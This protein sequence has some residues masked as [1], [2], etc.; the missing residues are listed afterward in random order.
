MKVRI[1]RQQRRGIRVWVVDWMD[2]DGKR[3]QPQFATK[4]EAEA[5]DERIRGTLR[6][7]PSGSTPELPADVTWT[8]LFERVMASRA[9]LK[10]RTL[11][12]YR[13]LHAT[14]IAPRFGV[15]AVRNLTRAGLKTFLREKRAGGLSASTVRLIYAT[16]HVVL[17]EAAEDGVL[18]G[19]P[20]AGLAKKLKLTTKAK[21]RQAAVK[22]K[23][24]TRAQRDAFLTTAET[25]APWWAPLWTVQ[26]LTGLRPG[27]M[28]ALEEGDL[29]L[30]H[31]TLT[32]ARTLSDDGERVDTPKSGLTRTVDLTNE[33]GRVLRAQA[34]RRREEK[35]R[36]GWK[37]LPRPLF[38]SMA[39]TY[40]DPADVRRAFRTVCEKA[41]LT[42]DDGGGA[43]FSPHSLRHTT[44]ALLLQSGTADVYYVQRMLGHADIALT[45]GTYG[46]WHRPDR[47]PNLDALDRTTAAPEDQEA[48]A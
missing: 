4:E 22:K 3:H 12:S 7:Q 28:Y 39:G 13:Y 38:P 25:V 48:Q 15:T 32:V 42:D 23:A 21:A 41:G 18:P 40:P 11:E 27:E 33:A 5:E 6:A 31:R 44:A 14:H 37:A 45:A 1:T 46:S 2:R 26:V 16:L 36:R 20:L 35:L 24:M 19:N 47:R 10:P 17:A 9:D 29:D 34:V 43:L 8:G 30:D